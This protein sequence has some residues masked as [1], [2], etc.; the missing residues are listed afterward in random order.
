MRGYTL[1]VIGMH[2][3]GCER[4]VTRNVSN[5]IGVREVTANAETG[6]VHV[7]CT[8]DSVEYVHRAITDAG[9]GVAN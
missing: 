9:Y 3:D 4:I 6:K 7:R 1:E 8:D 2:C 5:V